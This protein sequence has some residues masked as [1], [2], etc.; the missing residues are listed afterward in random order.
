MSSTV[1]K[2]I[3]T[4]IGFGHMGRAFLKGAL[5]ALP[6]AHFMAVDPA[7]DLNDPP[8]DFRE[9]HNVTFANDPSE[10]PEY[11]RR[12][13]LFVF[14]VKPQNAKEVCA[15]WK[16]YIAKEAA[17]LSIAAGIT[18]AFLAR[19]LREGQPVIRAMPN[20]ASAIGKGIA[21]AHANAH[22]SASQRVLADRILK[23]G[24]PVL[25]V[26]R[27]EKI[28]A[29]TAISGSGPAYYFYVTEVL[30]EAGRSLGLGA[31]ESEI[32]ARQTAIGAGAVL[33][34]F[35]DVPP[36]EYRRRVTSPGGTTA[37]ALEILMDGAL[38]KILKRATK[39]AAARS[40]EMGEE[41]S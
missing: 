15:A 39:A 9:T 13:A 1:D 30:A 3:I 29:V 26:D 34:E 25:W 21:G 27:E 33:E 14:A 40:A 12:S 18:H 20:L 28:D 4:F 24:G 2:I 10:A 35:P 17:F 8:A 16:S 36:G 19:Q 22:V 41:S 37:A 11:I 32:L 23:A 38:E 31:E 6:G 7:L 5:S